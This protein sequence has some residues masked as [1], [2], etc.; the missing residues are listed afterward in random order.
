MAIKDQ[1]RQYVA[2]NLM[3]SDNSYQLPDDASL[4]EQGILDSTGVLELVMFVEKQ[5][6]ISVK[7]DEIVRD[8]FDSV[9]SLAAYINRKAA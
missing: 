8:N 9:A 2:E 4:L 1:I 6:G 5:F 7:D 3:F